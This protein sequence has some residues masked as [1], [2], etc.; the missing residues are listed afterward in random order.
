MCDVGNV[1]D[2]K[3]VDPS[4]GSVFASVKSGEKVEMKCVQIG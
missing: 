2:F 4:A 1:D 3:I